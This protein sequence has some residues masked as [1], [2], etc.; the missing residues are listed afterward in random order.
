LVCDPADFLIDAFLLI[1]Q[2]ADLR[3][4]L[5]IPTENMTCECT[6]KKRQNTLYS[7]NAVPSL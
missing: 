7:C 3:V 6:N 1:I 5:N 2:L 4:H